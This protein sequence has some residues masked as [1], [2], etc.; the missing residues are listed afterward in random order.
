MVYNL[1]KI[2]QFLDDG[3]TADQLRDLCFFTPELKPIH[4]DIE[5]KKKSEI[6]RLIID[7]GMC[8]E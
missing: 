8:Q 4:E 5:G 6:I 3:F 7:Y 2:R 1:Q